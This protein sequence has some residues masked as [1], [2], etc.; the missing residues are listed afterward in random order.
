M[1]TFVTICYTHPRTCARTYN[2]YILI[3][4]YFLTRTQY[5]DISRCTILTFFSA[6]EDQFSQKSIFSLIPE[7]LF[8]RKLMPAEIYDFKVFNGMALLNFSNRSLR[9]VLTVLNRQNSFFNH[10]NE[11][12]IFKTKIEFSDILIKSFTVIINVP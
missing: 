11:K 9:I 4:L 1:S 10:F 5:C 3:N 2:S 12:S 6:L 8:L 7:N